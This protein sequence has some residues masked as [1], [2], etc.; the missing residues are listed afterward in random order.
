M[1]RIQFQDRKLLTG[2]HSASEWTQNLQGVSERANHSTAELLWIYAHSSSPST[3]DPLRKTDQPH[4]YVVYL[5]RSTVVKWGNYGKWV[6]FTVRTCIL[7]QPL[8]L[9]SS[10]GCWSL[11]LCGWAS[12]WCDAGSSLCGPFLD[13][14]NSCCRLSKTPPS[15]SPPAPW[16]C[17][18]DKERF[19]FGR[20]WRPES[21]RWRGVWHRSVNIYK[22]M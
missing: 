3:A 7:K 9:L 11:S 16:R 18:F 17:G 21:K 1:L 22:F 13:P 8:N 14:L 5:V 19:V 4:S 2:F 20:P 6:L 15:C 12:R 10:P